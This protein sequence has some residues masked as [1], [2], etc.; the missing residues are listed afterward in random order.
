MWR[1]HHDAYVGD[2]GRENPFHE[3]D[4][5][6]HHNERHS[7]DKRGTFENGKMMQECFDLRLRA[8]RTEISTA[9]GF[10]DSAHLR[11]ACSD[12]VDVRNVPTENGTPRVH[13]LSRAIGENGITCAPIFHEQIEYL[14][15]QRDMR[16]TLGHSGRGLRVKSEHADKIAQVFERLQQLLSGFAASIF[17][18]CLRFAKWHLQYPDV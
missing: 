10:P 11:V 12:P 4:R 13:M 9:L 6:R 3:G 1:N 8:L 5:I 14:I 2:L 18:E 17:L 15:D 7:D 16:N